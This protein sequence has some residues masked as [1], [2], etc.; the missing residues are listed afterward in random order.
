MN[1]RE[2]RYVCHKCIGDTTLA[3]QVEEESRLAECSY[4]HRLMAA[5]ALEELSDR[6]GQVMEELFEPI[7]PPSRRPEDASGPEESASE[8]WWEDM[9]D[10]EAVIERIAD[11]DPPIAIDIRGYLFDKYQSLGDMEEEEHRNPYSA[12]TWHIEKEPESSGL[13][14]AWRDF[15]G[16]I[17]SRARFFGPPTGANLEEIFANLTSLKTLWGAPVIREINPGNKDSSFWRGRAVYSLDELKRVLESPIQE[18]GPPPSD[19]A[20]AGRMNSEGIPVFYGA[21]EEETCLSEIRAPVGSFVVLVE[22]DLLRPIRILDLGAMSI[23]YSELSYFDDNY[24]DERSRERFL[25]ELVEELGRPIM[26][27]EESREYLASQV[28]AD[29]LANRFEGG[30]EGMFF[31]SSQTAGAGHNVV[32]FNHAGGVE[33]I[34]QTAIGLRVTVPRPATIPPPGAE[35]ANDF[36][37][38]TDPSEP[39]EVSEQRPEDNATGAATQK[40]D[41][42]RA[43]LGLNPAN[44]KV[45]RISGVN[46]KHE[47][48]PVNR[49]YFVNIASAV[50][51]SFTTS[52]AKATVRNPN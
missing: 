28:V 45:L 27:H 37:V 42:R 6:I 16:E 25:R 51:F 19:K 10:T 39:E 9:E 2:P 43:T 31:S 52:R 13:R 7:A 14:I 32:L 21:L 46:Y 44:L 17:H 33:D 29:Y 18:M 8:P 3:K 35:P 40:G 49:S 12:E 20:K 11:I 24:G 22:F 38:Q 1:A 47:T 48:Y 26:P 34:S 15:R 23:A 4:C 30:L 41:N 5:L 36:T 50:N